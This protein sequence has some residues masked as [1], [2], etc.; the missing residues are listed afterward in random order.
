MKSH[1]ARFAAALPRRNVLRKTLS[2]SALA[3]VGLLAIAG[4]AV[5]AEDWSSH[6]VAQQSIVK[7]GNS[8][9]ATVQG[10]K[11][12]TI[13]AY[14]STRDPNSTRPAQQS[15]A[16]ATVRMTFPAGSK[17]NPIGTCQMWPTTKPWDLKRICAKAKVGEGWALVSG[18][19]TSALPRLASASNGTTAPSGTGNYSDAPADCAADDATQYLR[20][21][22]SGMVF[23]RPLAGLGCLPQGLTW[24]HVNAYA[25]S[26]NGAYNPTTKKI[27]DRADAAKKRSARV[28]DKRAIIFANDNGVAAL[29]FAGSI[30]A[31]K[32]KTVTL[33]VDMP[34]FNSAGLKG[35]LPLDSDLVDFRLVTNNAKYLTAG[36]CPKSKLATVKSVITYNP[37]PGDYSAGNTSVYPTKTIT[38]T[39]PC[40]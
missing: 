14:L 8:T 7:L 22:E 37:F 39:S 18:L 29:S 27:Y 33:N 34:A 17:V 11:P 6:A 19:G 23:K 2:T 28:T 3:A 16:V 31:N 38:S 40:K 21:Y 32:D 26:G 9:G 1:E 24:V 36:A 20:T 4:N 10:N 13:N 30:T 12:A 5:A 25:G 15:Q 35:Y